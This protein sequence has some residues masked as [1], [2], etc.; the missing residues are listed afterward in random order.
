MLNSLPRQSLRDFLIGVWIGLVMV[1]PGLVAEETQPAVEALDA[2]KVLAG[3]EARLLEASSIRFRYDITA[4]GALEAHLQ[5]KVVVEEGHRLKLEG[6]GPFGGSPLEVSLTSDGKNLQG[7]TQARTFDI[8]TPPALREAVVYGF[9]RMG[10][11]HNLAR[12]TAGAP[13]D[14]ANGGV[15]EWVVVS[16]VQAGEP[17]DV[18]GVRAVPLSFE[19]TV[20]GVPSAS[21]TLWLAEDTGLPVRRTQ[22]VRFGSDTM[23]VV[24]RYEAF[25]VSA[26]VPSSPTP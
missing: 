3:L 5:G 16:D 17:E 25:E 14:H 8:S 23:G 4:E 9:L 12:L 10:L 7:G 22:T 18:D 11:L 1:C 26:P 6:S 20:S 21:A 24:E 19:I 15:Q 13:P 2:S